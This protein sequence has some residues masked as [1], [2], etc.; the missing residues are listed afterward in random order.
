MGSQ[1]GEVGSHTPY[2]QKSRNIKN[3]SDI[4]TNSMKTLKMVHIK[5]KKKIFKKIVSKDQSLSKKLFCC[6]H[7]SSPS[8]SP[9]LIPD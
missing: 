1:V 6:R 3:R 7:V 2:S 4:V 5:K 9:C 8:P